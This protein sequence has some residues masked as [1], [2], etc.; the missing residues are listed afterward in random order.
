M[1][2]NS[3]YL[4]DPEPHSEKLLDPDP[5]SQKMNADLQPCGASLGTYRF[6]VARR[7]A[8]RLFTSLGLK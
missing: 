3:F 4:L 6:L 2:T 1:D 7:L 5:D 8:S